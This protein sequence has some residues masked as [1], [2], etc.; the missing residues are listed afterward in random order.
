MAPLPSWRQLLSA[1]V[2]N[3]RDDNGPAAPWCRAG[4]IPFWLSRSAWSFYLI[5]K[6]RKELHGGDVCVWFPDYFCNSSLAHLRGLGV[7]LRFYPVNEVLQPDGSLLEKLA[8]DKPPDVFVLVHYFGHAQPTSSIAKFCRAKNCWLVEDSAHVFAPVDGIGDVGDFV[9][10]SPH[11]HFA[12]PRG[13]VLLMRPD[14]LSQLGSPDDAV[15]QFNRIYL[16]L[17]GSSADDARGDVLWLIKRILQLLGWRKR[18][19]IVDFQNDPQQADAEIKSPASMGWLSKRLL[20]PLLD[21]LPHSV[22]SRKLRAAEWEAVSALLNPGFQPYL[23]GDTPYLAGFSFDNN[24]NAYADALRWS[25]A[26]MPLTTWPDLPPEIHAHPQSHR[27]ALRRRSKAIYLPVHSSVRSSQI[28]G[29]AR[30]ILDTQTLGWTIEI[31]DYDAWLSY[32]RQCRNANL[33]QAWQYGDAKAEAE[34]WGVKRVLIKDERDEPVGI[35]QVLTKGMP[36]LGFIA[37]INRGPMILGDL[38]QS[39]RI[40]RS[41]L[42]L[43]VLRNK[44]SDNLWRILLVAPEIQEQ[45]KTGYVMS[46]MGFTRRSIDPWSS[47]RL[48]L[49]RDEQDLFMGL[50]GKWRNGLRKSEKSGVTV[51][52]CEINESS[53]DDL[54]R[55]YAELQSNKSFRG[56]S[57]ALISAMAMQSGDLWGFNL[58]VATCLDAGADQRGCG[59]GLLVC[60]R[61]GDTATYLI[62]STTEAGRKLQANSALLWEAILYSKRSGCSWFDVGGLDANRTAGVAKF[63]L[64]VNPLEYSMLGEWVQFIM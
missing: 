37:R 28:K 34:G 56:V 41:F 2:L 25:Q 5:V 8:S 50:N 59:L 57:N 6:Y 35:V 11:K 4:D 13:A 45:S 44:A 60:V 46:A 1:L 29:W 26:G 23:Q 51:S 33:L 63:K 14:G 27:E 21:D 17:I 58:F 9:L 31:L 30:R 7:D 39:E 18:A 49:L 3:T 16:E 15:S 47:A 53:L 12:I 20:A 64:G 32:W 48:D 24:S 42:L 61:S 40:R 22:E 52:R 54:M 38:E 62:G 19:P 10:Y 43:S 55:T 36:I